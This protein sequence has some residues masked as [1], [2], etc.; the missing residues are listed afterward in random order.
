MIKTKNLQDHVTLLGHVTDIAAFM[1]SLDLFVFPSHFEGS[2]NT[3]IETLFYQKPIVAFNVSSNPEIIQ[4]NVNGLLA[5][6][7]DSVDLTKCVMELMNSPQLREEFVKNGEKIVK[8]K[9]DNQ[10]IM[11][12]IENMIV[13]Q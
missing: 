6:A 7:F 9:F 4:H 3:L 5:K 13:Q 11:Q 1:N 10:K 12:V 2:A 8:E